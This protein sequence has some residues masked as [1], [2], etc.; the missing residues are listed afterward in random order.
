AAGPDG[1][2]LAVGPG[3]AAAAGSGAEVVRVAGRTLPGLADAHIHLD[4]LARLAVELDLAP[5]RSSEDALARVRRHAATLPPDAWVVGRG[6]SQDGWTDGRLPGRREL[7][8]A[9]GGR[10]V[11]LLR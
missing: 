11:L 2:I 8:L 6:W 7:G 9:G 4:A 1:R 10:P 5:A 3:A